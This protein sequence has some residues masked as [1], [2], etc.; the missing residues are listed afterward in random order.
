[1]F[2]T[3]AAQSFFVEVTNRLDIHLLI[4]VLG[5]AIMSAIAQFISWSEPLAAGKG[6]ARGTDVVTAQRPES[7]RGAAAPGLPNVAWQSA[8]RTGGKSTRR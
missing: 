2:L 1:V 8:F 5:I 3:F 4:A 6:P 7:G